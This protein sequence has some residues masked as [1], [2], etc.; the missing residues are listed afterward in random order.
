MQ[1]YTRM[2]STLHQHRYNQM[3]CL[4][5]TSRESRF[6]A[7]RAFSFSLRESCRETRTRWFS[8]RSCSL[9]TVWSCSKTN[10]TLLWQ[11]EHAGSP[12]VP[13]LSLPS[14][15][16][17]KQTQ[18]YYGNKNMLVLLTFLFSLYRLVLFQNKYNITMEN[19]T[20]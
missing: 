7:E 6:S 11:Q 19:C 8:S 4:Y 18:H 10:T 16:V 14:G 20:C 2:F 13:A 5:I 9:S 1:V 15:P 12:H 3:I 17:P